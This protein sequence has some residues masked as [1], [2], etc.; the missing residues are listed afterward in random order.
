M[1]DNL[2]E[3]SLKAN[4]E[5]DVRHVL[6]HGEPSQPIHDNNSGG[7]LALGLE[8]HVHIALRGDMADTPPVAAVPAHS[9]IR[10]LAA[11]KPAND[12]P[13]KPIIM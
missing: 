10:L 12:G 5:L 7:G 3:L 6:M 1:Y 11:D 9:A 13:V 8:L 4:L 2:T